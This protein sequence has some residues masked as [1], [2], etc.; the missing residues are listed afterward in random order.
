MNEVQIFDFEGL[1]RVRVVVRDGEPWFA[2]KDVC[3]I[4]GLK[5]VTMALRNIA[6]KHT[7]KLSISEFQDRNTWGGASSIVCVDEPGVYKLVF[8]S[9]LPEAE[10]F[11]DWVFETILPVV[12]K[13]GSYGVEPLSVVQADTVQADLLRKIDRLCGSLDRIE[14]K[15]V[16]GYSACRTQAHGIR[17]GFLR[18]QPQL[19]LSVRAYHAQKERFAELRKLVAEAPGMKS[20]RR[21]AVLEGYLPA[22]V[23]ENRL[24]EAGSIKFLTEEGR[25]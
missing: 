9:R 25:L 24:E 20:L 6:E 16:R 7:L 11:Q 1:N 23:P 10:K 13:N 5:N 18:M 2:A 17:E 8:K 12:R 22:A 21:T 15:E 19:N 4:L 14:Q 3:G